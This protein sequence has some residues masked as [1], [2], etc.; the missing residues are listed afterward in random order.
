MRRPPQVIN[1]F[2]TKTSKFHRNCHILRLEKN[3]LES[4]RDR[5]RGL[6]QVMSAALNHGNDVVNCNKLCENDLRP[7]RNRVR[8]PP[9][10]MHVLIALSRKY[11]ENEFNPATYCASW[12]QLL[13]CIACGDL[14]TSPSC[15]RRPQEIACPK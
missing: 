5:E 13:A 7:V 14:K 3:S 1:I 10:A 4:V 9:Q 6:P 11:H 12:K 2:P 15:M 8:Q